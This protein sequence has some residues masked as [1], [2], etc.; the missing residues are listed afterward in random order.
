MTVA[1]FL[2]PDV[3]V[4]GCLKP[5]KANYLWQDETNKQFNYSLHHYY[6]KRLIYRLQGQA[7]LA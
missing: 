4:N 1:G 6:A 7:L 2:E 3:N 5:T